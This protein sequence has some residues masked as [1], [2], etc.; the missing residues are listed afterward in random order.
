MPPTTA[1]LVPQLHPQLPPRPI[2]LPMNPGERE[3]HPLV[4]AIGGVQVL[5][6]CGPS[7]CEGCIVTVFE[8]GSGFLE[9]VKAGRLWLER[10]YREGPCG[11]GRGRTHR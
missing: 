10:W 9:G 7:R 3:R 5:A 4:T 6:L 2:R 8:A 11:R 1:V